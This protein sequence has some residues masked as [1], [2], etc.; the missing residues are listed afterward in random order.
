MVERETVAYTIKRLLAIL[1]DD[2][3]RVGLTV[4]PHRQR[5]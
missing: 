3:Q 5:Q 1:L 2:D 4:E